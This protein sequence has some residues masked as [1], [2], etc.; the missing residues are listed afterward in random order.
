M[1]WDIFLSYASEDKAG[2]ATPLANA[3]ISQGLQV[4]FDELVL[5]PGDRVTI[6]RQSRGAFVM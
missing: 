5:S 6:P 1:Q 2:F 4:W 3:L